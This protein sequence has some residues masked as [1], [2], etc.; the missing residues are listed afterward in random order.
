MIRESIYKIF[1]RIF[2][3]YELNIF[4]RFQGLRGVTF[5]RR[6]LMRTVLKLDGAGFYRGGVRVLEK[7]WDYLL[8]LDAGRPDILE[9]ILGRDV[10]RLTSLNSSSGIWLRKN[11][12]DTYNDLVMVSGNPY[13][14]KF[15]QDDPEEIFADVY[16]AAEY[17]YDDNFLDPEAVNHALEEA[18]EEHPDKRILVHYMQPHFPTENDD[19]A[20]KRLH[21]SLYRGEMG[22]E[23]LEEMYTENFRTVIER[24]VNQVLPELDGKVVV[25]ADHG[26]LLGDHGIYGHPTKLKVEEL[27]RVPWVEADEDTLS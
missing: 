21:K 2:V 10:E 11:F 17:S 23:E 5:I 16:D 9:D 25:S 12:P 24:G 20:G 6:Q 19:R 13:I 22:D 27:I 8:I 4:Y 15:R 3:F 1:Y 7:D 26:E 18:K 14:Y